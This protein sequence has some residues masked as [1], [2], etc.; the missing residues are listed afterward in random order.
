MAAPHKP[1]I[2]EQD[3][4]CDDAVTAVYGVLDSQRKRWL[5]LILRHEQNSDL[6]EELL[7]TATL[8]LMVRAQSGFEAGTNLDA[9]VHTTVMNVV[10]SHATEEIERRQAGECYAHE[11]SSADAEDD[12]DP[13]EA[14]ADANL[15]DKPEQHVNRTQVLRLLDGA[16]QSVA[17]KQP[18]AVETWRLYCLE[19]LS[20]EDVALRQGLTAAAVSKQV[21]NVNQALRK[22]PRAQAAFE[23]VC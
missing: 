2:V 20:C 10:R 22:S 12:L 5:A 8:K 23:A 17:K 18:Q 13:L 1:N 7:S 3:L 19:E 21:F 9:Y 6:A 4:S 16:L 14:T 15:S 11:M